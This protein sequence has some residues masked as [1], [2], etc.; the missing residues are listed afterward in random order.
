MASG[1]GSAK[2]EIKKEVKKEV[3]KEVKKEKSK[4]HNNNGPKNK[5]KNMKKFVKKEIRKEA[6]REGV[7]GPSPKFRVS[8][9][10]TMGY[11][12][13]NPEHGPT[14]AM[15][16]FL[17]PSLCKGPDEDAAFGPLQ[18]AAAQY[19][20][21]RLAKVT[22]RFTPLVGSSAVSGTVVR[23]SV[24]L[25]QNPS[26]TSWGGLGARKHRD[27]QAGRSGAFILSRREVAGPRAGGWWLTDTN[28]EG[29]Q[30][31]GP[32]LEVHMLGKTTSTYQ[33]KDYTGELFIVE[34]S[35]TWEFT[36]YSMNP[37]L[38]TLERHESEVTGAKIS[39]DSNGELQVELP[40]GSSLARFMDDPTAPRAGSE[41]AGEIVY[42]LVD[43]GAELAASATPPPFN[44]LI[45]GGWWFLKKIIGRGKNSTEVFKV[46]ASLADAQNNKPAISSSKN[47]S[48]SAVNA[49]LQ[50]TQLNSPNMGGSNPNPHVAVNTRC[51]PLDPEGVPNSRFILMCSASK[52]F[53]PPPDE[54]RRPFILWEVAIS[55]TSGG[56]YHPTAAFKVHHGVAAE[57]NGVTLNGY[58]DLPET[59]Q[60]A[61][62]RGNAFSDSTEKS[63]VIVAYQSTHLG[64]SGNVP[65]FLN[66]ALVRSTDLLPWR[67]FGGGVGTNVIGAGDY[68]QNTHAGN[69]AMTPT[70]V[71][72]YQYYLFFF[73]SQNTGDFSSLTG[74]STVWIDS[75]TTNILPTDVNVTMAIGAL[76]DS[77]SNTRVYDLYLEMGRVRRKL[78]K[79]EK[80]AEKLGVDLTEISSDSDNP[81]SDEGSSDDDGDDFVNVHDTPTTGRYENLRAAG[82]SHDE[83]Q[84]MLFALKQ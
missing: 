81:S 52:L 80:I 72:T 79:I 76:V 61:Y 1:N 23:A 63:V 2:K 48:G 73:L 84:N 50:V 57:I 56:S 29:Q 70:V 7:N 6:K 36:N 49:T 82:F 22:F 32:V 13:A 16:N 25:T 21:W 17:H 45:K 55:P 28:A 37:A 20:Q 77:T 19:G 24:N 68:Y 62:I 43:T 5:S 60:N 8:I 31:A 18:A 3:Q 47:L 33:D 40:A 59:G 58:Y 65:Y 78:T 4:N 54:N 64:Q 11:V 9:T 67:T 51:L 26:T 10:A 53:V 12:K 83:A 66:C 34:M 30:S 35:G 46:Y 71:S 14:L 74:S 27:F 69:K 41:T 44:W 42:Q 38:G 15:S 39:T 75:G